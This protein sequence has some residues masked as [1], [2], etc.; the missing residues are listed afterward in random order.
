MTTITF[1]KFQGWEPDKL[2]KTTEGRSY[3]EWGADN[4]RSPKW[5]KEFQT[6]LDT[7]SLDEIDLDLETQAIMA[8][9]PQVD[10]QTAHYAAQ[11]Q[12]EDAIQADRISNAFNQAEETLRQSLINCGVPAKHVGRIVHLITTDGFD[13]AVRAGAVQF[14][15]KDKE[16][17]IRSCATQY[18]I[19]IDS[20]KVW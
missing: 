5:R 11:E 2:A 3:L 1:G 13:D 7:V 4:L 8:S 19:D 10:Y 16:F 18:E 12:K 6:A 14:S 20:I 9:D 17:C 15:G